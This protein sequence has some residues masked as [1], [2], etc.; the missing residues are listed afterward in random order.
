MVGK[1]QFSLLGLF[2]LMTSVGVIGAVFLPW[3]FRRNGSSRRETINATSAL[4]RRVATARTRAGIR[5]WHEPPLD[6]CLSIAS[7]A[8]VPLFQPSQG[9]LSR[10]RGTPANNQLCR[11]SL[12]EMRDAVQ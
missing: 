4:V 9:D 2:V 11:Q 3:T 5:A 10:V 12:S 1:R 7:N 6:C 8:R